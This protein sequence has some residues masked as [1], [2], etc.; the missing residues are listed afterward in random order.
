MVNTLVHFSVFRFVVK[1]G[2]HSLED[3]CILKKWRVQ[4]PEPASALKRS[5]TAFSRLPCSVT[6]IRSIIAFYPIRITFRVSYIGNATKFPNAINIHAHMSSVSLYIYIY[7]YAYDEFPSDFQSF[8]LFGGS[9][10]S[11]LP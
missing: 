8:W 11:C 10:K 3:F 6:S 1:H 5:K 7:I 4:G 9:V 2:F